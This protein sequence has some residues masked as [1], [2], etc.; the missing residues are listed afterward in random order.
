[1]VPSEIDDAARVSPEGTLD[2]SAPDPFAFRLK[3][4]SEVL[5]II[6]PEAGSRKPEAGSR[7]PEAGSRKPE[8]GS[9]KPEAGSRKPEAGSRKP[10]AGSRKPE[11]GSRKPVLRLH[12]GA[13][14]AR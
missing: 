12:H 10:E 5:G 7:K 3:G 1:M 11:A 2:A 4:L 6:K 8:A 14:P 13:A 9:R